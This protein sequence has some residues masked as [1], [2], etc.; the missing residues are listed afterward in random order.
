M[1]ITRDRGRQ[2]RLQLGLALLL[3]LAG[4]LSGDQLPKL[5]RLPYCEERLKKLPPHSPELNE[6]RDAFQLW[7]QNKKI[8][9][10]MV[11]RLCCVDS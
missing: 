2:A 9:H 10:D 4:H 11:S 5:S 6:L 3:V 8:E 7:T 1:V